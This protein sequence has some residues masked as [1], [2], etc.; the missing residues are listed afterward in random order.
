[1]LA[2]YERQVLAGF[3]E[4]LP[5]QGDGTS[6]ETYLHAMYGMFRLE[7]FLEKMR[8][9][10]RAAVIP[11]LEGCSVPEI[12]ATLGIKAKAVYS[13]LRLAQERLEMLSFA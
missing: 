12:A 1:M 6:A 9:R 8:P 5:E 7:R 2:R 13:R 4:D 11:Y 3:A 10:I